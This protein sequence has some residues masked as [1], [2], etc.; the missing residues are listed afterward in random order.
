MGT[1]RWLAPLRVR[2]DPPDGAPP[3]AAPYREPVEL[4]CFSKSR[5]RGDVYDASNLKAYARP[6]VPFDLSRGPGAFRD[7]DRGE[8]RPADVTPIFESLR[9]AGVDERELAA[10]D[11]LTWRGNF[12]CVLYTGPHTTPFAW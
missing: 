10:A 3:R 5:E 9:R 2:H 1:E 11:V 12:R 8:R 6:D 4:A 7:R